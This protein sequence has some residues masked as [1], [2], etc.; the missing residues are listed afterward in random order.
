MLVRRLRPY[1]FNGFKRSQRVC[2]TRSFA[3]FPSLYASEG[4]NDAT[5]DY[6]KRVSQLKAHKSLSECYPRLGDT[7]ARALTAEEP[8]ITRLQGMNE[9]GQ[10]NYTHEVTIAGM[11]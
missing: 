10:T 2:P 9:P 3:A 8:L 11:G 6:E 5:H 1:L 7:R 4:R